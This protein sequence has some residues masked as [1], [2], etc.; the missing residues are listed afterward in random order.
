MALPPGQTRITG[1][2]RFGAGADA[3]PPTVPAEPVVE[4]AG[5]NP[6]VLAVPLSDLADLPRREVV[7]DFHCVAGWTASARRWEG[8]PFAAFYDAV[9]ARTVPAGVEIT[10]V[11]L[12]GLDGYRSVALLED[13]RGDDVLLA[14]HLDGAPL[15]GAH[16]AP[17]RL[18]SP[19]QYGYVNTKHLGRIE[20][21]PS[22]PK[23]RFHPSLRTHLALALVMPHPRARVAHEERHRYLPGRVVRPVYQR[24]GQALRRQTRR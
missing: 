18:V 13:L 22:E 8:I 16:G 15:D 6:E 14:D 1:F 24:L 4:V 21:H 3:P 17:L 11:A 7:A 23:G 5:G 10:H 19:G 12:T 20:L 9:V 2:P